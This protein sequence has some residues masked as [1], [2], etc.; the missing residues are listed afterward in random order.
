MKFVSTALLL[1]AALLPSPAPA[2]A[3]P[4]IYTASTTGELTIDGEGRVVEVSLQ[5]KRLGDDVIAGFEDQIRSWRFEP[6]L[7]AGQPVRAR[8]SMRL[9]LA[10]LRGGELPGLRLAIERVEFFDPAEPE[11]AAWA[12]RLMDSPHYPRLELGKGVGALVML[13]V[14]LDDEGHVAQVATHRVTLLG[15]EVSPR[16]DRQVRAFTE[17]AEKAAQGWRI[18]GMKG[19]VVQVP[20]RYSTQRPGSERWIRTR[21]MAVEVPDWVEFE[22]A[23]QAIVALGEGGAATSARWKLLTP[24]GG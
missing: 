6:I 17:S 2:Q 18:P 22:R 13:L 19:Q 15:E 21:P 3:E 5:R 11:P 4:E 12:G 23:N 7:Q 10:V 8:A 9:D 24:L 1:L 14:R 16:V 20:V